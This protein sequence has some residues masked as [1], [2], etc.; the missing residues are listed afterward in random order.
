MSAYVPLPTLAPEAMTAEQRRMYDAV[1]ASPRATGPGRS[2]LVRNDGSLTGPFDPWLRS[3]VI[4]GLLERVGMA[5]RTDAELSA[6][7]RE[8]AVLVVAHAWA[9][10]FEIFVHTAI[11][12]SVGVPD[13]LLER[14]RLGDMNAEV[15][16]SSPLQVIWRLAAELVHDHRVTPATMQRALAV[17]GERAVVEIVM[18]VGFYGLVSATLNAFP[19]AV[20]EA[21]RTQA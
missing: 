18:N 20:H 6:A 11:A 1:I 5:L 16:P 14:I 13:T 7:G 15:E 21:D 3:P 19:T 2:L 4:G 17:L 10:E 8:V 9:A 12:R